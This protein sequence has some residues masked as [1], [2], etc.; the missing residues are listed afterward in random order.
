MNTLANFKVQ[1]HS[2]TVSVTESCMIRS[3]ALSVLVS[4]DLGGG[5]D[6]TDIIVFEITEGDHVWNTLVGDREQ[7]GI[8]NVAPC[9][10]Y[11][12]GVAHDFCKNY[13]DP[14]RFKSIKKA[15]QFGAVIIQRPLSI[16][17][18]SSIPLYPGSTTH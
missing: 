3:V 12:M 11:L 5:I 9:V 1:Q 10:H 7:D 6:S 13:P 18:Q 16:R 8:I 2:F 17:G 4:V 14:L 15:H